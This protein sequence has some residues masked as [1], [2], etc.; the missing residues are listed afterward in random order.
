MKDLLQTITCGLVQNPEDV[1]ITEEKS[2]E[3][4]VV[5][6]HIR[7]NEADTGR[8]I[9]KQGR[10]IKAIR[11]VMRAAGIKNSCKVIVKVD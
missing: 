5:V 7:V 8:V 2:D 11:V 1:V 6:F 4:G 9:G 10:I 3:T